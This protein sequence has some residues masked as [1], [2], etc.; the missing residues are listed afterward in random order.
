MTPAELRARFAALHGEQRAARAELLGLLGAA[1]LC[2]EGAEARRV[3]AEAQFQAAWLDEERRQAERV[4][5]LA[6]LPPDD[7]GARRAVGSWRAST[8]RALARLASASAREAEWSDR[9]AALALEAGQA[10][11]RAVR[12]SGW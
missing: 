8:W 12:S 2:W 5:E 9:V 1:R 4:A 6:E 3:E 11:A 7:R 10:P